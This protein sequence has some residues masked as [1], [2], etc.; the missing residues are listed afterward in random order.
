[1]GL[2]LG[3]EPAAGQRAA[4]AT[5][6]FHRIDDFG[7]HRA[8]RLAAFTIFDW[9]YVSRSRVTAIGALFYI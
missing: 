4:A 9:R 6:F 3:A 7:S 5:R 8:C 1:M 2:K